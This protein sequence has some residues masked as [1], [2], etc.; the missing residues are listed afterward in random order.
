M[1]AHALL[2]ASSAHR[3]LECPPSARLELAAGVPDE[4]S[5]YA[6]EGTAA[7]AYAGRLKKH[8]ATEWWGPEM[9]EAV[10]DYATEVMN[11][12]ECLRL[13][14]GHPAVEL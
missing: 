8:K 4:G 2:G 11:I 10:D 12:V 13:E 14:G 7:H 5:P 6:A 1:G 3:W 9:E